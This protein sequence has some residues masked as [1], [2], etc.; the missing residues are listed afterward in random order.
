MNVDHAVFLASQDATSGKIGVSSRCHSVSLVLMGLSSFE[1][2]DTANSITPSP[3]PSHTLPK[4]VP[5][6]GASA[7][8]VFQFDTAKEKRILG[9]RFRSMEEATRDTLEYFERRGW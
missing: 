1:I 7:A 4:G 9:I 5:G 8:D 6:S 3:I 2:V